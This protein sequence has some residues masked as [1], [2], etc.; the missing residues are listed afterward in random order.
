MISQRELAVHGVASV[1]FCADVESR[2][3]RFEYISHAQLKEENPSVDY[4]D[5]VRVSEKFRDTLCRLA[6]DHPGDGDLVVVT[7]R[8]GIR[9][10]AE[11]RVRTPYVLLLWCSA[12][13]CC[14]RS[15]LSPQ[16]LCASRVRIRRCHIVLPVC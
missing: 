3:P 13:L 11:A 2:Q 9:F 1:V 12:I 10:L 15:H 16:V 8:E 6:R 4:R 14:P 7:H 5:E